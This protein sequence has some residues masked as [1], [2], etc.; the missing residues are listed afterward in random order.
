MAKAVR[1]RRRAADD[2]ET[3]AEHLRREGD[4]AVAGRFVDAVERAFNHL[5]RHPQTGSPRFSYELDIP[6]LR[7]WPLRRFP[8]LVFV[9]YVD[10]TDHL[11]IWRLLHSARDI[12]AW[13]ADPEPT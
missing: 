2:I 6:G 8:Y 1:L 9:F 3:V 11:D 10:E 13:L 7:S 4:D 12:S 5:G